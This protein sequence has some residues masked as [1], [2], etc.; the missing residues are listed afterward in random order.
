MKFLGEKLSVLFAMILAVFALS[1]AIFLYGAI[2]ALSSR[3]Q[4]STFLIGVGFIVL[5]MAVFTYRVYQY[6]DEK[7]QTVEEE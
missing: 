4:E 1:G 2:Q 3:F 7:P 5:A 6:P